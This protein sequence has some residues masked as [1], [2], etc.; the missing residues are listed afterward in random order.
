ML[1]SRVGDA[2]DDAPKSSWWFFCLTGI[3]SWLHDRGVWWNWLLFFLSGFGWF[4]YRTNQ[5]FRSILCIWN[6]PGVPWTCTGNLKSLLEVKK[7]SA[8]VIF[9]LT[10][11]KHRISLFRAYSVLPLTY[12]FLIK[13]LLFWLVHLSPHFHIIITRRRWCH[14]ILCLCE[15]FLKFWS[16]I[17]GFIL[18]VVYIYDCRQKIY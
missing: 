7:Q 17:T 5:R 9:K 2:S 18:S 3:T 12:L 14:V 10:Y 1:R 8:W 6:C 11:F 13:T 16:C 4:C 15:R